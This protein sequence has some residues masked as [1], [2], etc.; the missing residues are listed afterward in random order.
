[1][2]IRDSLSADKEG[3]TAVINSVSKLPNQKMA[4]G[5]LLNMRF[6]PGALAGEDNLEK[7]TC[8]MEAGRKKNIFH[9][10]FN[11][12]DSETLKK[13]KAHPEDCPDL[14]VR[15]AGYCALFSTLM[16]EAQDAIIARSEHDWR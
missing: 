7:F 3:P 9:N 10:Q 4:G 5:Q 11:I 6:T 14:M 8:F 16:P 2:C 15:V 12:V 1:M 13:A